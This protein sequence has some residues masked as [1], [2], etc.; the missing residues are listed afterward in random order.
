MLAHPDLLAGWTLLV[1]RGSDNGVQ[2][3][4]CDLVLVIRSR[5]VYLMVFLEVTIPSKGL[6]I[7]RSS[8]A[9]ER[10]RLPSKGLAR[11][12]VL[13]AL[14]EAKAHA[15]RGQE[16]KAFSLVYDAGQEVT[17]LLK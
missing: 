16:G 9:R 1:I 3:G 7:R 13:D 10:P 6:E 12:E 15:V 11:S 5:V 4:R 17:S 2:H 14:K 8:M